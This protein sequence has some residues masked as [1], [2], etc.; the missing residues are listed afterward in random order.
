MNALNSTIKL[1]TTDELSTLLAVSKSTVYRL[2]DNREIAF[3]KVGGSI[4]F[5]QEDI[6]EYL[7]GCCIKVI[8]M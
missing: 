5:A 3:R 1:I 6:Q 2:I 7:D 8:K 4:R